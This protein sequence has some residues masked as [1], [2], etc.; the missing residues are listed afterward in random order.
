M[1]TTLQDIRRQLREKFPQAHG[2]AGVNE[3]SPEP[4]QK[5]FEIATFPARAISEIIP[6]EKGGVLSLWIAGI[7][8]EPEETAALPELVLVDAGDHFDPASY[9]AAACSRLLWVRCLRIR[10]ALKATDMLVRDGNVPFIMLDLY[11]LPVAELRTIPTSAWWRLKQFCENSAC[12]LIVLSP[13]PLVPCA[14]L[15]LSLSTRLKLEDFN[16]SRSEILQ[17][18]SAVPSRLRHVT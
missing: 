12:R 11:G 2:A 16:R 4:R 6:A 9:T 3:D 10:E 13:F 14:S 18:V 7:L 5:P 17:E 1:T 15:R 8:G